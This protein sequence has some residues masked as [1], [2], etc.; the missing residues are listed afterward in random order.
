MLTG[1]A[2]QEDGFDVLMTALPLAYQ[3]EAAAL[4]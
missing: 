2:Y 1:Y 4:P 3:G